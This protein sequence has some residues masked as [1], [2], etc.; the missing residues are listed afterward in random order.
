MFRGF[1]H[2]RIMIE[3]DVHIRQHTLL[4]RGALDPFQC[5]RQM[6]MGGMGRAAQRVEHPDIEIVQMRQAGSGMAE[7]SGR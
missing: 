1:G 6:G 4:G 5:L 3:V 2:H 7:T